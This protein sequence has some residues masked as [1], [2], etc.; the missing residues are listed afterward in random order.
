MRLSAVILFLLF[1]ACTKAQTGYDL[2]SYN[3]RYQLFRNSNFNAAAGGNPGVEG[4]SNNP[5]TR[6]YTHNLGATFQRNLFMNRDEL[7]RD[8]TLSSGF[9]VSING[10]GKKS[11]MSTGRTLNLNFGQNINNYHYRNNRYLLI[12]SSLGV[13]Q[14]YSATSS[15]T[16]ETYFSDL[17]VFG[18]VS[19]GVGKGRLNLIS[20]PAFAIFMLRDFES[21]GIIDSFSGE[22][23]EALA[24]ALTHIKYTR[25][26]DFRHR[27]RFQA[28]HLDSVLHNTLALKRRDAWYFTAL[29]DHL[30]YANY[31]SR[32]SGTRYGISLNPGVMLD[33]DWSERSGSTD[34]VNGTR[35]LNPAVLLRLDVVNHR[36]LGLN[37]QRIFSASFTTG[38]SLIA[39][40][41]N[42]GTGLN[43]DS[44]LMTDQLRSRT[45]QL[46]AGAALG[47]YPDT[48]SYA[49]LSMNFNGSIQQSKNSSQAFNP[50][51]FN[52]NVFFRGSV[53]RWLGPRLQFSA[54]TGL[55]LR[56]SHENSNALYNKY[57]SKQFSYGIGLNYF[58]F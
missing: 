55:T 4:Y 41:N 30:L 36:A 42:I 49:Q 15:P 11:G 32:F 5:A 27:T 53:Y 58:L 37:W 22:Q 21:Q 19:A 46:N 17:A 50:A 10:G 51:M 52:E 6:T 26:V 43:P 45:Y 3:W 47:W 7:T 14:S 54:N 16:L 18:G 8:N 29:Y 23:I 9:G 25:V 34:E 1:P 24:R 33:R 39:I 56:W 38:R 48:R 13:Y 35:T 57:K 12:G 2:N 28:S 20:D 40:R 44:I 31:F